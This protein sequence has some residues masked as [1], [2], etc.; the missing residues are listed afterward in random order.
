[1]LRSSRSTSHCINFHNVSK[2][3]H[4]HSQFW[5]CVS[6]NRIPNS[7]IDKCFTSFLKVSPPHS[8]L[9]SWCQVILICL[10][11]IPKQNWVINKKQLGFYESF[12]WSDFEV[13]VSEYYLRYTENTAA[14]DQRFSSYLLSSF[15]F[16]NALYCE[17]PLNIF[18]PRNYFPIDEKRRIYCDKV[19]QLCDRISSSDRNRNINNRIKDYVRYFLY[20]QTQFKLCV[21]FMWIDDLIFNFQ[22]TNLKFLMNSNENSFAF[23]QFHNSIVYANHDTH[24]KF[25]SFEQ[26]R[27]KMCVP[28][29]WKRTVDMRWGE[30]RWDEL[31]WFN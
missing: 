14:Y 10:N 24:V 15:K 1:M 7:K 12:D 3:S 22:F 29:R 20:Q 16:N 8:V 30:M 5:H 9:K 27:A 31:R 4:L 13:I 26:T 6:I 2:C 28:Q 17:N 19:N 21:Y 11:W 25:H 18:F 23:P